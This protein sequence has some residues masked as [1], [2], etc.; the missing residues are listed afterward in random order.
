MPIIVDVYV[1]SDVDS[2]GGPTQKELLGQLQKCDISASRMSSAVSSRAP[3]PSPS[4]MSIMYPGFKPGASAVQAGT[5]TALLR[6]LGG[7]SNNLFQPIRRNSTT[8]SNLSLSAAN[9]TAAT[10]T[11][12]L[13]L[14]IPEDRSTETGGGTCVSGGD[15]SS[16]GD[17]GVDI[18]YREGRLESS[19]AGNANDDAV[20]DD[21][22]VTAADSSASGDINASSDLGLEQESEEVKQFSNSSSFLAHQ[23]SHSNEIDYTSAM[24]A[25][26]GSNHRRSSFQTLPS[27]HSN[28]TAF[29]PVSA[30]STATG[31]ASTLSDPLSSD[32]VGKSRDSGGDKNST[33]E[34]H[35]NE[36]LT[37]TPDQTSPPPKKSDAIITRVSSEGRPAAAVASPSTPHHHHWS[38]EFATL[39]DYFATDS[40][41]EVI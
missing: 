3:S 25:T 17:D 27:S 23:R 22:T 21:R 28:L 39:S 29:R 41:T 2:G 34:E 37:L 20:T 10:S 12:P 18:V 9:S 36:T 8:G 19:G 13:A 14:N 7:M 11:L 26:S 6:S 31:T 15:S 38:R 30:G 16:G 32:E 40:N 33:T 35:S 4:L 1:E 24:T 5:P